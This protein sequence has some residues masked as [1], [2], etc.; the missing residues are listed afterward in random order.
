MKEKL[1][2]ILG[3][4]AILIL[5]IAVVITSVLISNKK[6]ALNDIPDASIVQII[7]QEIK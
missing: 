7:E 5:F 1:L 6:K 2:K 4:L 3:I